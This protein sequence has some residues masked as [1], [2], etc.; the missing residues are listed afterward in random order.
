MAKRDLDAI[1]NLYHLQVELGSKLGRKLSE[2]DHE[3]AKSQLKEFASLLSNADWRYMGGE[4][5]YNSL[6]TLKDEI[7][8][9]LRSKA[10]KKLQ[11]IARRAGAAAKKAFK[12]KK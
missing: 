1:H 2:K 9:Q 4:D 6:V 7:G 8:E 11:G 3:K 5:V 12:R 10:S